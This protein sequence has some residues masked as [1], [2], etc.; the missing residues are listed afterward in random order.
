MCAHSA[1]C[2]EGVQNTA[3]NLI[4]VSQIFQWE[5]VEDQQ[6]RTSTAVRNITLENA[7]YCECFGGFPNSV[8]NKGIEGY[9]LVNSYYQ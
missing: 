3:W 8:A 5:A 7:G 4:F 6:P 2:K 9:P 1:A